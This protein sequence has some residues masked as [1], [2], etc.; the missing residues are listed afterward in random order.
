MASPLKTAPPQTGPRCFRA[1][2][3]LGSGG[4]FIA[5]VLLPAF[6]IYGLVYIF[7][8]PRQLIDVLFTWKTNIVAGFV[9]SAGFLLL[10]YT[11]GFI[12]WIPLRSYLFPK[13]REGILAGFAIREYGKR[14]ALEITIGA[15]TVQTPC[16]LALRQVF[17]TLP[18][19]SQIRMTTGPRNSVIRIEVLN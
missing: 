9:Y 19:G 6:S 4:K 18:T 11:C 3:D 13:L 5:C 10:I 2:Y 8:D 14:R 17:E 7:H 16:P 15:E 1:I 12:L